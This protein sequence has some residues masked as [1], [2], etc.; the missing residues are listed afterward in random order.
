MQEEDHRRPDLPSVRKEA[1]VEGAV[2]ALLIE[3]H[4]DRLTMPQLV[5]EMSWGSRDPNRGDAVEG[6][7]RELV[8]TGLLSRYGAFVLPTPAAIRVGELE[9]GL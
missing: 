4:P 1:I 2:L 7:V 8:G 3:R 5:E 9:L 6:A